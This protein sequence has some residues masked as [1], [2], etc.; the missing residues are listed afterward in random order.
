[1]PNLSVEASG[2]IRLPDEL[3]ERYGFHKDTPVRVIETRNGILLVP[4]TDA[5]V[6]P[7][8]ARELAEW[9]SMAASS[10]EMFDDPP[11]N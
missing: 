1:M 2:A 8:L 6:S 9:Q 4:L 5:P 7:E 10:W 3:R 11:A